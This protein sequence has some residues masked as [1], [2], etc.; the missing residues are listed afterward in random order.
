MRQ[1]Q[2]IVDGSDN[3]VV[4]WSDGDDSKRLNAAE[5]REVLKDSTGEDDDDD[6]EDEEMLPVQIIYCTRTHSQIKQFLNELAKTPY[7]NKVRFRH[8]IFVI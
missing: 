4:D 8:F 2:K 3:D 5:W 6:E 1:R 7:H